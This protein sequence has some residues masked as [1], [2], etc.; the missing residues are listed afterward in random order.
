M[1]KFIKRQY[2][3]DRRRKKRIKEE[4]LLGQRLAARFQARRNKL[5]DI[6]DYSLIIWAMPYFSVGTISFQWQLNSSS[7]R[8][9]QI[10]SKVYISE[11]IKEATW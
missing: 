4:E 8:R 1:S 10:D 7:N 11:G 3:A 6:F 2:G 5:E 9:L